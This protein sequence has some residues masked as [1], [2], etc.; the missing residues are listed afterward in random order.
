M[1]VY[2]IFSKQIRL[3]IAKK[4]VINDKFE[5]LNSLKELASIPFETNKN[6]NDIINNIFD[7]Y[8]N[9]Y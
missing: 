5:N 3:N 7:K 1:D 2:F 6:N 4:G 9:L 8:K